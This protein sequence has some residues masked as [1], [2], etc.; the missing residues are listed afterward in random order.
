MCGPDL[1]TISSGERRRL[2]ILAFQVMQCLP[3]DE[4]EALAVL[5]Y[6]KQLVRTYLSEGPSLRV[7]SNE[8]EGATLSEAFVPRRRG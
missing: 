3:S 1:S 7:L 5:H 4:L 6:A 8:E 2:K